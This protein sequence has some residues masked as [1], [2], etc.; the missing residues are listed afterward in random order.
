MSRQLIENYL[1]VAEFED[2]KEFLTPVQKDQ[3]FIFSVLEL[4]QRAYGF[5]HVDVEDDD[6][7]GQD[8]QRHATVL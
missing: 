6:D 3:L 5:N 7:Q 8:C 1:G 2:L 4:D